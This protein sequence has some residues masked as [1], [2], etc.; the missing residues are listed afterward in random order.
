MK[1]IVLQHYGI[2]EAL[3]EQEIAEPEQKETQVIVEMY[4]TSINPGDYVLRSGAAQHMMPIQFPY[5]PGT[6]VAGVVKEVGDKVTYVKPGDLVMGLTPAVGGAYAEY[7]AVEEKALVRIPPTLSFQQAAALPAV[8]LPAWQALFHYSQVQ[9]GQRILIHAAAGGVGHIA[10]QLAKQQG[11]YVIATARTHNHEFVR[12]LGADEVI[13]YSLTDF[14]KAIRTPVDVVLDMVMDK[15][16]AIVDLNIGETGRKSYAVLKDGGKFISLVAMAID[17]YPEVRG[18]E[19]RFVHIQPDRDDLRAALQAI[20]RRVQEQTL[21]VHVNEIFPFTAQ[22]I[23]EAYRR[24]DI[25]P[26]RGK[27]V[28]Q[29]KEGQTFPSVC[30]GG[31]ALVAP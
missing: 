2:P 3:R 31:N 1:A 26:K 21:K 13:D 16:A 5:V 10:V 12:Q 17:E 6:D 19:A 28:I 24:S 22:G 14:T 8:A 15:T 27:I 29:R 18:I 4:A 11:A 7:V 23:M 20:I 9:P 30:Q 25:D